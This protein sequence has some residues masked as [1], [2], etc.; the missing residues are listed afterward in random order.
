M[1]TAYCSICNKFDVAS[2]ESYPW[3]C[4]KGHYV[5]PLVVHEGLQQAREGKFATNP[6]D[7]DAEVREIDGETS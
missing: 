6:P 5:Y 3:L 2:E 7:I 4:P 1:T